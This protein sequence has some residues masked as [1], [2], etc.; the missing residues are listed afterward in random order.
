MPELIFAADETKRD[1]VTPQAAPSL[2]LVAEERKK[3]FHSYVKLL[4]KNVSGRSEGPVVNMATVTLHQIVV[5][6]RQRKDGA[7]P[8]A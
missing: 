4:V 5:S 8:H 1:D 7:V 2:V 6:A 3:L